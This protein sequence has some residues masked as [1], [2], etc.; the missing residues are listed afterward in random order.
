MSKV[1]NKH[2]DLILRTP[3][4]KSPEELGIV[5]P[6]PD[7]P[8]DTEIVVDDPVVPDKDEMTPASDPTVCRCLIAQYTRA[9]N[10]EETT[11][12]F[13]EEILANPSVPESHRSQIQEIIDDE[14]DHIVKFSEMISLLTKEVY[15]GFSEE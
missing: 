12:E 11:I 8:S 3:D 6:K 5:I 10:D 14:K 2:E 7:V 15:P 13:Y 4:E 9:I 1:I